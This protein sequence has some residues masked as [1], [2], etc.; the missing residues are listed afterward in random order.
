[1]LDIKVMLKTNYAICNPAW[2]PNSNP[3]QAD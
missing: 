1:M 2:E 3:I